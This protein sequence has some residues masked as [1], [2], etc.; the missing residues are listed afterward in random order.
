MF[1]NIRPPAKST[2]P[3]VYS[4]IVWNYQTKY[5]LYQL[6]QKYSSEH[7]ETSFLIDF[8]GMSTDQSLNSLALKH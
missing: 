2:I 5:M 1:S 8:A 7:L 6:W 4:E 3:I